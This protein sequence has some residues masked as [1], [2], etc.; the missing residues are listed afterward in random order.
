M[1]SVISIV[2][3]AIMLGVLALMPKVV[4]SDTMSQEILAPWSFEVLSIF[5]ILAC[6]LLTIRMSK[7]FF[8]RVFGAFVILVIIT[9]F[10]L[11]AMMAH[12]QFEQFVV[13]K[14][15]TVTANVHISQISDSVYDELLGAAY[16]QQAFIDDL[17]PV[18]HLHA[19]AT[20]LKNPFATNDTAP[21][22]VP[23]MPDDSQLDGR[24]PDGM[25]VLLMANAR[26]AKDL[27]RLDELLPNTHARMTLQIE[28]IATSKSASGFDSNVWLRTRGI[29]ATARILSID[30]VTP[31]SHDGI[32]GYLQGLRQTLRA[33]FYTDWHQMDT[34]SQRAKA[35]TLSLLT[36]D[37]ALID[38]ATKD[39]YQLAG[40]SHLLAISGTHVVFLAVM[41]A[42]LGTWLIDKVYPSLYMT[43]AR[44]QV[45]LAVMVTASV[46]YALFTGFDVPAVRTVY[47]L[48][49]LALARYLVLPLSNLSILFLVGLVMAW[50]DPYVLWQA[51]FWLS[52]VAVLLLMR[53]ET[54]LMQGATGALGLW[55]DVRQ[56]VGLQ[57][58]LF[59][60]MLPLSLLFFGKVSL[61]GV[62]VNLFAVG[63]FG[64]VIVPV[65]LLAG[66]VFAISPAIADALWAVSSAILAW[67]HEAFEL[68]L[69]GDSWL[70]APFGAVGFVLFVMALLP[71][72]YKGLPKMAMILP[73]AVLGLML[74]KNELFVQHS[75]ATTVWVVPT[76][77]RAMQAVLIKSDGAAWLL[78]SDFGMKSPSL[79]HGDMLIDALRR[80]GVRTL[81]GVVVQTPSAHLPK[82]VADIHAKVPVLHYWQ[83]G[84]ET[85]ALSGLVTQDCQAGWVHQDG[86]LSLRALTGWREIAD[87]TVW[88]CSIELSSQKPIQRIDDVQ[89]TTQDATF[90]APVPLDGV[91][92]VIINAAMHENT[93]TLWQWI[94]QDENTPIAARATVYDG[95]WLSHSLAHDDDELQQVFKATPW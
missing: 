55:Q 38:R 3:I 61:W 36:G 33:H 12:H 35:V 73:L 13:D 14:P 10:G 16:R 62:L 22:S 34:P 75:E 31:V 91:R 18:A 15:Y 44:W 21:M 82:M 53:Y 56:L 1:L 85:V 45:R 66:V 83:A 9:L 25:T 52:F 69:L 81:T 94:C 77:Q 59:V 84:R 76:D 40:I 71:M 57:V 42:G 78:L 4:L 80:Q 60:A 68:F 5:L 93:W 54:A 19:D 72:I 48:G 95:L 27:E 20:R 88:G 7:S 29:H 8:R 49:V 11:R 17:V 90:D 30:A 64:A 58:W 43:V 23:D 87:E 86:E 46:I 41:L 51:G 50:L 47:M 79:T 37:R 74:I 26:Q 89:N 28:P 65:N 39:L 92:R 6:V 63:L 32:E 24:L 67:L 2:I 70:Y